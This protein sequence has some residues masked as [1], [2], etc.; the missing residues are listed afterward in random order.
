MRS[1]IVWVG[2]VWGLALGACNSFDATQ[3][4]YQPTPYDP[5][6]G[7]GG[8]V[9]GSEGIG[10]SAANLFVPTDERPAVQS[11]VTPL[12]ISGGTLLVTSDASLAVVSDPD[13][14]LVS[15]V[16][17][18]AL[19]NPSIALEPGDQPGRA[20]EDS[21]GHIHVVLRGSGSI[22]DIDVVNKA[23]LGRR[24]VCKAPR[25]IAFDGAT[26]LLHVACAEGKVVSL[27][28]DG[29]DVVRTV[30][31]PPDLRDVMV[32]GTELWVTRF[33]SAEVLRVDAQGTLLQTVQFAPRSTVLKHPSSDGSI[34]EQPVTLQPEV[35]WRAVATP[36]GGAVVVQQDAVEDEISVAEA[37]VAQAT[38]GG[39][40]GTSSITGFDC[41]SI[42]QNGVSEI[43]ADGAVLSRRGFGG[44]P[45][46]VDIA[47][48]PDGQ[49]LA[50]AHAGVMD[51]T[52]PQPSISGQ[53]ALLVPETQAIG[54]SILAANGVDEPCSAP[55]QSFL[56][57][58]PVVSVAFATD[59]I[60]LAQV[61]EPPTLLVA[62]LV[63]GTTNSIP[64]NGFDDSRLDTGH[65]IFHRDAGAGI[66]CAS[67]H[68][69]GGE[70]G[71]VWQF[72]GIGQRR[73]QSLYVGLGSTAPFHWNGD[74]SD[75]GA[76]MTEVFVGRMGGVNESA[77]RLN[78]LTEWLFGLPRPPAIRDASDA[79][80]ARGDTL[81]HSMDVGCSA[82]HSGDHFTDNA[83]VWVGTTTADTTLQVPSLIAIGY[84]APFL[85]NGCAGTLLDRFDPACGG[86][87]NH[88]HTSALTDAEKTDLVA[89][90]E[91]L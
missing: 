40:Y 42:V 68:P 33:K 87:D 82:C 47:V 4:D 35:A 88:G 19:T 17:I 20:V 63:A 23:V 76:L 32:R 61:R 18:A 58:S 89:Y 53:P 83:N 2:A 6:M 51:F 36:N 48:S 37:D 49:K 65:E 10:G 24:A 55:L 66:A 77:D 1:H 54:V 60:V 44:F 22:A 43:G 67:C 9:L 31:L 84:R 70:D 41:N 56:G 64:L 21:S 39:S 5:S 15:I 86:G 34:S 8:A 45:L 11:T 79:A 27:L 85:H 59:T 80:V 62:D 90:L 50:I 91:S 26:G 73:T 38:G 13:R 71:H 25:G 28:A 16:S 7:A 12:P 75:I 14:D 57:T 30:S 29:G 46:P 69:E 81:F 3:S 52:A 74:L 78:V 72:G